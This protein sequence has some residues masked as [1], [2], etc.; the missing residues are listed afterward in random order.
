[1]SPRA[2]ARLET[3]GFTQVFDYAAGKADWTST[4]LP[5]EGTAAEQPRAADV[6][7]RDIPTCRPMDQLGDA[8]GLTQDADQNVCIVINDDKVVLG[9]LRGQRLEGD[10][11][12]TVESVMEEGP[13][14]VRADTSL[15]EITERMRQRHVGSILVTTPEGRLIGILYRREAEERLDWGPKST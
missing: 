12:M 13:T 15:R 8:R 14:T 3:F 10:P 11:A 6:V 2:A 1:M 5:T 9:R 4:G 7:Q